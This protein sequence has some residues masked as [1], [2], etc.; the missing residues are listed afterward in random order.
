[1]KS[2][3]TFNW[4]ELLEQT[5]G[6]GGHLAAAHR[7]FEKV[8]LETDTRQ[9]GSHDFYVPLSGASFDGHAFIE[10]AY[11]Q[12]AVGSLVAADYLEAHPELLRFPNLIAVTDT[13][14][15]YQALARFHRR[16]S[17]AKVIAIT[18]SSGKTTTKE[19]LFHY[20]S[21]MGRTQCTE[22][23]YNNE[24]GVPHTLL[25]I[26]A[27]T[28]Y[29]V[30]EMGMRGLGQIEELA[31]CAEP[32]VA[33]IT[34]V[35]PAHIG[36]LG[37]LQAIAQA[38]CEVFSGLDPETGVGVINGD[39]PLLIRQVNFIW[40]G[41]LETFSLGE[42]EHIHRRPE[43]GVMFDYNDVTFHVGLPGSHNV[44]NALGCIKVCEVLHLPLKKL[45]KALGWFKGSGH[46]W[47]IQPLN[48]SGT[49]VVINDA[50]NA[51]P[52]SMRAALEAFVAA[53][54]QSLQPRKDK[55]KPQKSKPEDAE[56][57]QLPETE[58]LP[59]PVP[60]PVENLPQPCR[61]AIL[62][63]MSELGDFSRDYHQA[64]GEWLAAKGGLHHLLVVGEGA[65]GICEGLGEEAVA[66]TFFATADEVV[67]W[68]EARKNE[69]GYEHVAL[70][71]KASRA[72]QLESVIEPLTAA[73]NQTV[74]V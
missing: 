41:Q 38:K 37:S 5:H 9:L 31:V 26:K 51:N 62:G 40:S 46:R 74:S 43:G 4:H 57:V 73:L 61:I 50:Y 71:L 24:V 15:A 32:D 47:S 8:T 55:E 14:L 16:R 63:E 60:A 25:Q 35:G 72:C 45:G 23:N 39:D 20:L 29:A 68:L 1:M 3:A 48:A 65:K 18:G 7:G 59:V 10:Q 52:D 30:V 56:P 36:L 58:T 64:L 33:L 34:N 2:L 13:L 28:Q 66:C 19:M 53:S 27:D 12:G 70:L 21:A 69:T 49:W 6:C 22:K 17:K 11:G 44:M 54:P 67:P 42:V